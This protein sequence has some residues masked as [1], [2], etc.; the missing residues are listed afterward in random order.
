[1]LFVL[2]NSFPFPQRS[3]KIIKYPLQNLQLTQN[4]LVTPTL[5]VFGVS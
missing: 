3:K 2:K 1:M 5:G 4:K